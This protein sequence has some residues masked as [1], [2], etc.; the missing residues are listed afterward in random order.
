MGW[1]SLIT[2]VPSLI[3]G[4]FGTVN[5]I[6]DAISNEKIAVVNATTEQDR[7]AAQERVNTLQARRDVM[8]A[9]SAH[10]KINVWVRAFIAFG[11]ASYLFKIFFW[12][13]VIGSIMGCA[14]GGA[15]W[16]MSCSSFTTDPIDG[17]LW[18][19]VMIVLGF[20]FLADTGTAIARIRTAIKR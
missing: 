11:P 16:L 19:V 7:I 14:K 8:I 2:S 4:L 5:H 3:S 10:S 9:E 20:Y 15:P 6:T 12:D 17:N 1:L 18:Q 13:K